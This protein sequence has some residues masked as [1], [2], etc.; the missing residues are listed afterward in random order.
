MTDAPLT[1]TLAADDAFGGHLEPGARPAL[2]V[3][4]PARAYTDPASPL[5]AGVEEAVAAMLE[6]REQAAA[7]GIPIYLT[8]VRYDHADDA[9][10]GLF[11]R[12]VPSLMCF[13]A[14]N[15][16]AEFVDGFA[17]RRGETVVTK[18]YPSAFAG[19]SLA[20]SL[21]ARGIDTVLIAGLSTSGCV[22]ATALDALQN[23]FVP[24]VVRDCVG[25]RHRDAHASNLR[26][27]A[28]K[29]G[30]VYSLA[31][32]SDYLNSLSGDAGPADSA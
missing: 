5:Y 9:L 21:T 17:P 12:K 30:E 16:L 3:V 29:V 32:A 20:A 24:I 4:D 22:R 14:G 19:T 23:G 27:I 11:F 18:H 26:D 25:D 10:G 31:Q 1:T 6:F 2:V 8:R 28:A 15:P 13:V 7:T